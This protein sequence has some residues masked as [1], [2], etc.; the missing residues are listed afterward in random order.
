MDWENGSR[1]HIIYNP[2]TKKY[3][4]WTDTDAPRYSVASSSKPN[5][6]Y[7]P[8]PD[9]TVQYQTTP[10]WITGDVAVEAFGK[11]LLFWGPGECP[12]LTRYL[13][14]RRKGVCGLVKA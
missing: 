4:G 5:G 11:M 6:Q 8:A 13:L 1:P 10:G 9:A 7:V 3:V 14:I 12:P 2:V